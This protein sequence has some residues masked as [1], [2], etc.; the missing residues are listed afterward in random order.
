MKHAWLRTWFVVA[1]VASGVALG[2]NHQS[3]SVVLNGN[4]PSAYGHWQINYVINNDSDPTGFVFYMQFPD[5]TVDGTGLTAAYNSGNGGDFNI[6]RNG[7]LMTG[8]ALSQDGA[9]TIWVDSCGGVTLTANDVIDVNI[10]GTLI[11]NPATTGTYNVDGPDTL[12]SDGTCCWIDL[13]VTDHTVTISGSGTS[14]STTTAV[15][16]GFLGWLALLLGIVGIGSWSLR[17]NRNI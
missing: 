7:V 17:H 9:N 1:F 13:S 5:F 10:S 11:Q 2:G 16:V 3:S 6:S 15:P 14:S 8:C 4:A 12:S